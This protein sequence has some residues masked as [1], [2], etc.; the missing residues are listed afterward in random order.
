MSLNLCNSERSN[1]SHILSG[2]LLTCFL[3]VRLALTYLCNCLFQIYDY[4]EDNKYV[5]L[6]LELCHNG[7]FLHYLDAQGGVL[8][9]DEARKVIR[10]VVEGM[11]YLQRHHIM[12]RDLKLSNLLLTQDMNIVSI[13][14]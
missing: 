14:W 4:D 12:H 7:E 3:L 5:Y 8:T 6:V 9:E 11:Q 2:T 1:R 13:F 10:Q